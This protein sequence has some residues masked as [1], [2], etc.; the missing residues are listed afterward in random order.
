LNTLAAAQTQMGMKTSLYTVNPKAISVI[1]LYG[2]LDSLTREWTD[3][4]VSMLYRMINR[5]ILR[6]ERRYLVFDGDVDVLWI[7]NMECFSF[8]PIN[9][10]NYFLLFSMCRT[11]LWMIIN[12]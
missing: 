3:G 7:E 10:K 4:I 9:L 12:Y 5:P 1:E 8:F 11:Q 6:N 2:T